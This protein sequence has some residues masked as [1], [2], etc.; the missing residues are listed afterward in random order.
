[1]NKPY[2]WWNEEQKRV[3][4]EVEEFVDENYE[5]A[6]LYFWKQEFPWPLIKK[7]SKE[8]YF[9]AGIPKEYGGMELGA[10]GSCIVAEQLGRLY[11]VGHVF[12]VSML[13]GLEQILT[14]ATDEQKQKWLP[15]LAEGKEL[16]AVCITE[17]FAG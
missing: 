8:G 12:V 4:R 5:Q 1:M 13:A 7:V 16:G 9:G 3:A 14:Y 17:P 10:T 2:F 11:S 15:K 6:E